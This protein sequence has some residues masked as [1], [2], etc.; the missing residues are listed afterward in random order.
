MIVNVIPMNTKERFEQKE[1][2]KL[3][4]K[5]VFFAILSTSEMPFLSIVFKVEVVTFR[6]IHLS[7]LGI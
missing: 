3:L 5:F 7:S 1:E 6:V 4:N 2:F